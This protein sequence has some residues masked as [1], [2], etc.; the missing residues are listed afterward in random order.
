MRKDGSVIWAEMN[1]S[2]IRGA[3]GKATFS[4][5][6]A[7]DIT[8]R[9]QME[10]AVR[11][12]ENRFQRL[13]ENAHDIIFSLSLPDGKYEYI[14]PAVFNICGYTPEELYN[15]TFDIHHIV[16][17][18]FSEYLKQQWENQLQ[19]KEVPAFYEFKIIHRNGSERWVHQRNVPLRNHDGL[20]I[21]LEGI[22]TDITHRKLMEET[23]TKSEQR[24]RS[25][26]EASLEA[27][28]FIK[29][30]VIIDANKALNRL[31]GYEEEES[32]GRLATD[33]I[34]PELRP[35]TDE[36]IRT[37][38]KGLYETLGLRKDGST[39]PIE[40]NSHEYCNRNLCES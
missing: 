8:G 27:I 34:A 26:S 18:V 4:A 22:V 38:A 9:V 14:S 20:L 2:F 6:I 16:H 28:V 21:A 24:F 36:R 10:E 25:L 30:G 5:V 37:H 40:V 3:D 33:F 19:G 17:P 15:G 11:V 35:F 13:V 39:F 31:F 12:R 23:V 1:V 7:R 32:R 29:D